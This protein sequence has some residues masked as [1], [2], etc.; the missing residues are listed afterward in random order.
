MLLAEDEE[1]FPG[2]ARVTTT[3][4]NEKEKWRRRRRRGKA[5][6]R[7]AMLILSLSL[8]LQNLCGFSFI[9]EKGGNNPLRARAR[10]KNRRE[11]A[12][13]TEVKIS[14]RGGGGG[15]SYAGGIGELNLGATPETTII[16]RA[17][18]FWW[19]IVSYKRP[20]LSI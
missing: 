16:S 7:M 11:G 9:G 4:T 18:F 13:S 10:V 2:G 19:K 8:S 12:A 5:G 3:T 1:E 14:K 20:F 17:L 15:D 6:K